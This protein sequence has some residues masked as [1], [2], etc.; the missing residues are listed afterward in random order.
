MFDIRNP[1]RPKE[2]AYFNPP[3]TT[4]V[5]GSSHSVFGQWRAG[6]PDWCASRLDFDFANKQLIT[7]CQ[8]NGLLVLRFAPNTWPF[9]ESTASRNQS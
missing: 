5:P 6:G 4:S 1:A 9:A 7:M 8:D 3:S 2:I